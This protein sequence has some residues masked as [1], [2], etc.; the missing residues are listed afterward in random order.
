ML[1][2][3][4]DIILLLSA[5]GRYL[6]VFTADPDLLVAPEDELIG[7]RLQDVMPADKAEPIQRSIDETLARN[8]MQR[9]EYSLDLADG[10]H[11]FSA[12]LVPFITLKRNLW[13]TNN[14]CRRWR[15][16]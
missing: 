4:P 3:V 9:C 12:R 16:N 2:A 1:A 15:A 6:S 14:G 10:E 13:S 5:D 8:E 11:W 7:R